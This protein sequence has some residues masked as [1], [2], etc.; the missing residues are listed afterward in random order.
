L[1]STVN[2]NGSKNISI[3]IANF[4]KGIYI[5]RTTSGDLTNLSKVVIQ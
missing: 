3:D 1:I 5:V 2:A 4:D